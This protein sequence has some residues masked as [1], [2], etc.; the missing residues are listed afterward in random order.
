MDTTGQIVDAKRPNPKPRWPKNWP[1]QP[2]IG[3]KASLI[4][5]CHRRRV[6][7]VLEQ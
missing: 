7:F 6:V 3:H 4:I 5:A 1:A 2:I